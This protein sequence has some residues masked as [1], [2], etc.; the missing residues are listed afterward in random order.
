MKESVRYIHILLN[1]SVRTTLKHKLEKSSQRHPSR[2]ELEY[3]E[4]MLGRRVETTGEGE[5]GNVQRDIPI[6]PLINYG[7][8]IEAVSVDGH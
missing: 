6:R 2:D 7:R 8:D 1:L 4:G 3:C 5:S